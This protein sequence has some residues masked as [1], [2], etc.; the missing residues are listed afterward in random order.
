MW[1]DPD[2]QKEKANASQHR[3]QSMC[4]GMHIQLCHK[5]PKTA[6]I[7]QAPLQ[8]GAEGRDVSQ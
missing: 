4:Q 2:L 7:I 8:Q 5:E 1:P 3:D 6:T